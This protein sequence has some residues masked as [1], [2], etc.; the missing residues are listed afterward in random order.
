MPQHC[1]LYISHSGIVQSS[2]KNI[3]GKKTTSPSHHILSKFIIWCWAVFITT[4][5]QMHEVHGP[6][7]GHP[8]KH[9]SFT[10]NKGASISKLPSIRQECAAFGHRDMMSW[11]TN[12]L[13]MFKATLGHTPQ[14]PW[15]VPFSLLHTWKPS[16]KF[17]ANLEAKCD[18]QTRQNA[19]PK[20]AAVGG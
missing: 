2:Y 7:S 20:N 14:E 1:H 11:F 5:G 18:C 6:R 15:L 12:V 13:A 16:H 3:R 19:R 4:Q 17:S 8:I 9:N 10:N